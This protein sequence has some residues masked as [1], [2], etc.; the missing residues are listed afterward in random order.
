MGGA[1]AN[2]AGYALLL[3]HEWESLNQIFRWRVRVYRLRLAPAF[4]IF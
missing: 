2:M 3:Q 4:R 1:R